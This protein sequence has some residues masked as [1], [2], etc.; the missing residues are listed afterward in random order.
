VHVIDASTAFVTHLRAFGTAQSL[1]LTTTCTPAARLQAAEAQAAAAV[2][3]VD[4]LV[5][6]PGVAPEAR[7]EQFYV[8]V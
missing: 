7:Q 3:N 5:A 1:H 2:M 4:A 8:G 6:K